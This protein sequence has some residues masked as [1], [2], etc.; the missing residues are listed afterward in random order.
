MPRASTLAT[1]LGVIG[2]ATAGALAVQEAR[3]RTSVADRGPVDTTSRSAR[4]AALAGVGAKTGGSYA[5][6]RAK[7]AFAS[8]E[9]QGQLDTAFELKT[10]ESITEALGNMK[11]AMMKL[12]QMAS[13]LDQGMPEHMR[14]ALAELQSNAP[15]MSAALAAKVVREELGAPPEKLFATWDP[16]PIAAASIGQVHRALLHD[17]RSVAVK[18]QYPGV[19]DAIRS[20]LDNAGLLFGA[21]GMLFPGLQP[22]PLVQ[23]LRDRLL[24]ELDYRLEADNQ[25]LFADYYEGHPFIHVPVVVDALCAEGVLT[26]E[27]A[28][29][30]HFEELV[31][32]TQAERDLAAETIFRFVFGSLYRLHAFNGDPHPGNYLF[33]PG[34]Q[35]TFLDF[36]LVKRFTR[37]EVA[38][39]ESMIKAMV[40]DRDV[41]A[42]HRIITE[43]GMLRADADFT[44]EQVEDY[45]GHFYDFVLR[46]EVR[47]ITP[48]YASETVRRFF[49][50]SGDHGPIMKAANVPPSFVIIQRINLGLYAIFGQ[51]HATGNWRRISEE[52]WPFVAGPPSTD[53]GRRAA[54]WA[55]E[56]GHE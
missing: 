51:L 10:A 11:G 42:F 41:V 12:G 43:I 2:A 20:D 40:L 23:E 56:R 49:N 13:Y 39:L 21:M 55:A 54:T 18:V 14:A 36:G 32:W 30:V 9:R 44:D 17:G 26:T 46:D 35:V 27:L 19:G 22:E 6:H 48:E 1:V 53:L 25:R 16:E 15:P 3:R 45:F 34:G 5:L 38:V 4:N 52:I 31:T 37:P 50:T 47:T 29:G 24:E 7:R 28:D 8:A 33:G